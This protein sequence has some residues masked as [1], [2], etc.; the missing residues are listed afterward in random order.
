M[1]FKHDRPT[2]SRTIQEKC[3]DGDGNA[4]ENSTPKIAVVRQDR[5]ARGKRGGDT[6]TE[7]LVPP[8]DGLWNV[9]G[10][11]GFHCLSDGAL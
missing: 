5:V 6:T 11:A 2:T 7:S 9:W 4:Q 10:A 8:Q 1:I 3:S